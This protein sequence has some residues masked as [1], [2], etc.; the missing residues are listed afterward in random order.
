MV[1]L[2]Q[3]TPSSG[4]GLGLAPKQCTEKAHLMS[5][6][7]SNKQTSLTRSDTPLPTYARLNTVLAAGLANVKATDAPKASK[8]KVEDDPK[9]VAKILG[10]LQL[11]PD[12]LLTVDGLLRTLQLCEARVAPKV[13]F[14]N[15]KDIWRALLQH[16]QDS[17]RLSRLHLNSKDQYAPIAQQLL[18]PKRD[19]VVPLKTVADVDLAVQTQILSDRQSANLYKREFTNYV[20][21]RSLYGYTT[22]APGT[23]RSSIND[24]FFNLIW[25]ESQ[26]RTFLGG[27]TRSIPNVI[28]EINNMVKELKKQHPNYP[29][30][31][32]D[33]F[34]AAVE[35][36]ATIESMSRW[37][38]KGKSRIP[39]LVAAIKQKDFY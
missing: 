7:N 31:P 27:S 25:F 30:I 32:S 1:Q 5:L 20:V 29:L 13:L 23:E 28:K 9:L 18:D 35:M 15:D 10:I 4:L 16:A 26:V 21:Y 33:F 8:A 14:C 37:Y 24:E 36:I 6:R 19:V 34:V 38:Q 2:T 3:K 11:D 22:Y 12:T 39:D 17:T